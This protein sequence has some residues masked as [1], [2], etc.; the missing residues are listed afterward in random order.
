VHLSARVRLCHLQFGQ[1]EAQL[2]AEV[3]Q[4]GDDRRAYRHP[5]ADIEKG[6]LDQRVLGREGHQVGEPVSGA[7][8]HGLVLLDQRRGGGDL[9]LAGGEIADAFPGGKRGRPGAQLGHLLHRL[10][11]ALAGA[12]V[13]GGEVGLPLELLLGQ[14][15]ACLELATLGANHV[16]FF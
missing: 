11:V 9:G 3:G 6:V 16:L 7:R 1:E 2:D 12:V 8:E 13:L 5:F 4:Q 10:V 15:H 14:G